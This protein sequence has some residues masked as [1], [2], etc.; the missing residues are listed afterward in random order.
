MAR[1][2]FVL[3]FIV[4]FVIISAVATSL[5]VNHNTRDEGLPHYRQA[6]L[7]MEGTA[8]F[9]LEGTGTITFVLIDQKRYSEFAKKYIKR[10]DIVDSNNE[11]RHLYGWKLD[12]FKSNNQY[13]IKSIEA[14]IRFLKEEIF[15]LTKLSITF[16]DNVTEEYRMGN[17]Q[18][19]VCAKSTLE[20]DNTW[21]LAFMDTHLIYA[22]KTTPFNVTGL[23]LII[24]TYD[25][26]YTVES[27]DIGIPHLSGIYNRIIKLE[28]EDSP[29]VGQARMDGLKWVNI[30][31]VIDT[32]KIPQKSKGNLSIGGGTL[33]NNYYSLLIPLHYEQKH[34]LSEQIVSFFP[35]IYLLD[36]EQR[37]KCLYPTCGVIYNPVNSN[38]KFNPAKYLKDE[39]I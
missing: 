9:S 28:G 1:K 33:L 27:I 10:I 16:S 34:N 24:N 2:I 17:L 20:R 25:Q 23:H 4:L 11:I 39:G 36:N 14:K 6:I 31:D 19:E 12:I 15:V 7:K 30:F 3:F 22:T 8:F 13:T 26:K 38:Q 37:K 32:G 29:V 21:A 18:V 35:K 5:I